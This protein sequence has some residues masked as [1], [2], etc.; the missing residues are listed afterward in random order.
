V[1]GLGMISASS[2]ERRGAGVSDPW[3]ARR[4]WSPGRP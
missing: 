2:R 4:S 3:G 1:S